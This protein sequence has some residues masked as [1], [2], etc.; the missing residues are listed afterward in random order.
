M[1]S[2]DQK[3][4]ILE[5]VENGNTWLRA[6]ELAEVSLGAM[7]KIVTDGRQGRC[8]ASTRFLRHLQ[9]AGKVATARSLARHT[10]R[11]EYA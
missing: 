3:Q 6:A 5:H 7:L 10:K 11:P 8:E 9:A 4:K 2:S 1:L